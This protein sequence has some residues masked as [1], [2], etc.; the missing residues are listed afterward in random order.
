M[1]RLNDIPDADMLFQ[2]GRR[3]AMNSVDIPLSKTS[4]QMAMDHW[5][6]WVAQA[7]RA[8]S[9]LHDAGLAHGCIDG[10]ALRVD[11]EAAV[12][13]LGG[14]QNVFNSARRQDP[15]RE[16]FNPRSIVYPP[17]RLMAQG[18][19][20]GLTFSA[21]YAAIEGE[22]YAFDQIPAIFVDLEYSR[23]VMRHMYETLDPMD[24]QAGDVWMLAN[25]LFTVYDNL[26]GTTPY[27][28]STNFY[29][30]HHDDFMDLMEGMLELEPAKRIT[31]ADALSR[32]LSL[33]ASAAAET[34]SSEPSVKQSD[35]KLSD[36]KQSDSKLSDPKPKRPHLVLSGPLDRAGRNRTRRSPRS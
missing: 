20:D 12:L 19:E 15:P 21:I 34:P 16:S 27:V 33:T 30:A 26:L 22:N 6:T 36:S 10:A 28:M 3:L 4:A 13:R 23:P 24:F 29:R 1:D 14:L 17:E 7:L 32:W 35:S 2:R 31:A 18:R 11:P 25:T 5:A 9:A 8:L